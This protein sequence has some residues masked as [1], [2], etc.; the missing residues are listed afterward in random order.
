[1]EGFDVGDFGFEI[2]DLPQVVM[3]TDKQGEG[4]PT[5]THTEIQDDNFDETKE[6]IETKVKKGDVWQLGNHRMCCG[7]S[8]DESLVSRLMNGERADIT[9]SSPPYNMM[10]TDISK[11]FT[12]DKVNETYKIKDGTYN[13]FSDNLSDEEYA[14]L[15]CNTL[16][17]GLRHSD[18][19]LFNVGILA[20]SKQGIIEMLAR[21]R[22]NFC[23]IIV[24]NKTNSIPLCLP[25]NR[26]MISHRCELIF[27]FNQKGNRSF[28]HP[29][30]DKG[31][32]NGE[33]MINRI[34]SKNASDNEFAKEH[35]AVF[36]VEF[37]GQVV[38]RFS[39]KSVLELF[40][41]T[42]T[43]LIACEQLNRKCFIMEIDPHYCDIIIARWE[44][45]TG[46]KAIKLNQ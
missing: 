35:H 1:V 4:E 39:E 29:Q 10:A 22:K 45:L 5:N 40:G 2:D 34:D 33:M 12:S 24:W 11:I 20:S 31:S 46:Q 15:L 14:D 32:F 41:G 42:G 16:Q 36:P 25:S 18:D 43:T 19:V 17:M 44:K 7:D 37:A 26:G 9:F 6:H 13:E 38:E 27:C 28:S 23:D 8:T 21:N 3:P 30:W